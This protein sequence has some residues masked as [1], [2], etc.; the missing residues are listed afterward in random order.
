MCIENSR[1][2]EMNHGFAEIARM[3]A[4]EKESTRKAATYRQI[5]A[6]KI[7]DDSVSV[8]LFTLSSRR[9]RNTCNQWRENIFYR[10]I[11]SIS[12]NPST[13]TILF[14]DY[15]FREI[16][17]RDVEYFL[18]FQKEFLRELWRKN[19]YDILSLIMQGMICMFFF[20]LNVKRNER[21]VFLHVRCTNPYFP[22]DKDWNYECVKR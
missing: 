14:L 9:K 16:Q 2:L 20:F 7:K 8:F 12:V 5:D 22:G 19:F 4:R 18:I 11:W 21:C 13:S 17:E 3:I 15:N 10:S 6:W 1:E